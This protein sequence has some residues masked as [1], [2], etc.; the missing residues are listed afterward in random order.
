[1]AS[2]VKKAYCE[3]SK[4]VVRVHRGIS[5]AVYKGNTNENAQ[6]IWY[7]FFPQEW[8]NLLKKRGGGRPPGKPP[9]T[10]GA[11]MAFVRGPI[12]SN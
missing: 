12:K 3:L 5:P 10:D 11:L 1:M 9:A 7:K 4:I 6:V 2:H 8:P